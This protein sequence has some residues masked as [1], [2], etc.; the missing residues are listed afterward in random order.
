MKAVI[1]VL[2]AISATFADVE[3][4]LYL[5][6]V[7]N[8]FN[9]FVGCATVISPN[10]A[11][12][13]ANLVKGKQPQELFVTLG[14]HNDSN[15]GYLHLPE[16]YFNRVMD[17][18]LNEIK[19][20]TD[21][22]GNETET[23]QQ[24]N[25]TATNAIDIAEADFKV[26]AMRKIL[27]TSSVNKIPTSHIR[28]VEKI[29]IH[30]DF[31]ATG[32]FDSN[33]AILHF[34]HSIKLQN[35]KPIEIDPSESLQ[36]NHSMLLGWTRYHA[37]EKNVTIVNMS[38]CNGMTRKNYSSDDFLCVKNPGQPIAGALGNP[39]LAGCPL[40]IDDKL[41]A[42]VTAGHKK[43]AKNNMI[44]AITKAK[45]LPFIQAVK[46]GVELGDVPEDLVKNVVVEN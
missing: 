6:S 19:N 30:P 36:S 28:A 2:F 22:G 14:N 44:M 15:V 27:G 23:S 3:D 8:R 7:R 26:T 40:V 12:T 1:F 32:K 37:Y 4:K 42:M 45:L 41:V 39:C 25:Q 43:L 24:Q 11:I 9:E 20:K 34:E 33:I 46:N 10:L 16:M 5:A 17:I 31:K 38:E 13:A 18:Y 35:L 29:N 21:C